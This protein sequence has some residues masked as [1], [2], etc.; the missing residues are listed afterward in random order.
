MTDLQIATSEAQRAGLEFYNIVAQADFSALAAPQQSEEEAKPEKKKRKPR[1][2][3]A[4]KRPLTAY[5]LYMQTAR[6][7]CRQYMPN[8][9]PKEVT[10]EAAKRWKEM[11]ETDRAV[12][13][14][15]I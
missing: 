13:F 1:D 14:K 8:A 11:S 6:Q 5:F 10:D 7:T 15:S 9:T 3:N 12:S 2:P 4:P